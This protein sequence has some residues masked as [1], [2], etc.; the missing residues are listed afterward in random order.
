MLKKLLALIITL[1]AG[2]ASPQYGRS[3]PQQ[4]RS[5]TPSY[6]I[7][8]AVKDY[9]S[10][11]A[12]ST[13]KRVSFSNEDSERGIFYSDK[14]TMATTVELGADSYTMT[15]SSLS[16]FEKGLFR[17]TRREF[18]MRTHADAW[19][20]GG[21]ILME[22]R[23]ESTHFTHT[24]FTLRYLDAALQP[25]FSAGW[26]EVRGTFAMLLMEHKLPKGFD[27]EATLI[28]TW[29]SEQN[30]SAKIRLG[31]PALF[32]IAKPY[33]GYRFGDHE[34]F[35]FNADLTFESLRR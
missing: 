14:A 17:L 29:G 31:M 21:K 8:D 30:F 11:N 35:L 19:E 7:S 6:S 18:G 16:R 32:G 10:G 1:L 15:L 20:L 33:A 24:S 25:S 9:I 3:P 34:G 23:D 26:D 13:A 2:C 28:Q 12:L 22:S 4:S 27:L 5:A